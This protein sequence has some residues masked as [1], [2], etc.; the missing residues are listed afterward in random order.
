MG[1]CG[2]NY[3]QR[4]P[5]SYQHTATS[6][7]ASLPP[8]VALVGYGDSCWAWGWWTE[9]LVRVPDHMSLLCHCT[10]GETEAQRR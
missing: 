2:S 10:D 9:K 3:P 4:P 6:W 8:L 1:M 7:S 5:M